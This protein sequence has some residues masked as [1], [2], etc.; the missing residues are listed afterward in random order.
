MSEDE[1][2][3]VHESHTRTIITQDGW[4]LCLREKDKNQLFNLKKDAYEK[5][6]LYGESQYR[7]ITGDLTR[8]IVEWQKRVGDSVDL[9][10]T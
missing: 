10:K 2:K 8:K 3:R 9:E 7:E 4:K 1:A 5:I 6:N